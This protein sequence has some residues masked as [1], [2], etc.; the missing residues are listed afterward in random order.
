VGTKRK[1]DPSVPSLLEDLDPEY[2]LWLLFKHSTVYALTTFLLKDK[3]EFTEGELNSYGAE[4]LRWATE[5]P[6]CTLELPKNLN[7]QVS[8]FLR[9][10]R[11]LWPFLGESILMPQARILN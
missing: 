5:A 2:D 11:S 1:L 7:T 3:T 8:H 6:G 4:F 10:S 9:F